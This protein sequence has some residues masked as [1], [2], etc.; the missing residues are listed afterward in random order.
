MKNQWTYTH[1]IGVISVSGWG[2]PF[3]IVTENKFWNGESWG[4]NYYKLGVSFADENEAKKESEK[5]N[6][7]LNCKDV[8][9]N[10]NQSQT[11]LLSLQER[12]TNAQIAKK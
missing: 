3:L 6:A 11:F 2:N 9:F 1:S 4:Y 8:V 12:F 5:L 10:S 7:E